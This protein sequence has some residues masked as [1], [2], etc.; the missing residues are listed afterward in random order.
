VSRWTILKGDIEDLHPREIIKYTKVIK[1][2]KHYC[3]APMRYSFAEE[4]EMV[5]WCHKTFGE[6]GYNLMTMLLNWDY[7]ADHRV[8]LFWFGEEQHLQWFILRWS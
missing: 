6:R 5:V 4:E 8:H 7:S 2:D 3:A 1:G